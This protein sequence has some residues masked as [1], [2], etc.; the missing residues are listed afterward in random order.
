MQPT[1]VPTSGLPPESDEKDRSESASPEHLQALY[2]LVLGFR[3]SQALYVVAKLGIADRLATG[4]KD[5][6][7][8]AQATTSHAP[9]LFRL[10]RFLAGVGLFDEV[11]PR[12]FAL[13]PLGAGLRTEVAGSISATALHL[14]DGSQWLAWSQLLHGVQTGETAFEH[15]HGMGVFD[16]LGQHPDTAAIFQQAMTS[17]TARS[18]VTLTRGYDWSGIERLVDVG[19]GQG[20]LL[21]TVLQAYP[22]LQGVLFDRPAVVA[23]ATA[24]LAEAGVAER[25]VV[26][27]GDFFEAVPSDG[28]AYVMR[29][30]LH[31]WDDAPAQAI[32]ERCREAMGMPGRLLVVERVVDTDH[33][34]ALPALGSDLS[35]MVSTGGRER[36]EAEY[37]TLFTRAG[38]QLV[39]IVPLGD[40]DG[41]CVIEG[42][43]A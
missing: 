33:H 28:D 2:Q 3:A 21:A 26:V 9:T 13:T 43:P 19:G 10:L 42:I 35:M 1:T 18:S 37:R 4:P 36:T 22:T 5:I 16:Y 12:R 7:E 27:G 40:V 32:L 25:C 24:T 38:F 8:L 39:K 30:I 20:L 41:F 14:L 17:N 31:D 11:A 23:K 29:N 6:E 34:K 15:V